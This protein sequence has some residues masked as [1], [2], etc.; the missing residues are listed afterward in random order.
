M[1]A[2]SALLSTTAIK[3]K[4]SQKFYDFDEEENNDMVA[5]AAKSMNMGTKMNIPLEREDLKIG[6]F[7]FSDALDFSEGANLEKLDGIMMKEYE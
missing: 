5:K 6:R 1:L 4:T 3:H 2:L 7:S